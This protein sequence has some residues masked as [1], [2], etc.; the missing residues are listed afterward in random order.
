[1]II[2]NK[3]LKKMLKQNGRQYTLTMYINRYFHLTN[4]QLEYVLNYKEKNYGK[5]TR[6]TTKQSKM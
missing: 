1:M 4:A 2:K 3:D 6:K 5:K